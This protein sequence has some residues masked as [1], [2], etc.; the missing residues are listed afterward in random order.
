MN[1]TKAAL[2]VERIA[3]YAYPA[4]TDEHK[5]LKLA[6]K[7]LRMDPLDIA[8]LSMGALQALDADGGKAYDWLNPHAS[9]GQ[10]GM[11]HEVLNNCLPAIQTVWAEVKDEWDGVF[12]YDVVE[13]LGMWFINEWVR[14][15]TPPSEADCLNQARKWA[16]E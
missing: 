8:Y 16:D 14:R 9:L 15:E 10:D 5:A 13:P 3:E 4:H 1:N 7:S 6:V 12:L 11:I 2:T